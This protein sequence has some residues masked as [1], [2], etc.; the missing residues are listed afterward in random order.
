MKNRLLKNTVI[1]A[2]GNLG[3]KI[4]TFLLV[5]LY[6]YVLSTQE[7]GKV[8]LVTTSL[9]LL[10]PVVL[11]NIFDSSLR[12]TLD[13]KEKNE[14]VLSSSILVF[15]FTMILSLFIALVIVTKSDS[16]EYLYYYLILFSQGL[17]QI[18][19]QYARGIGK[20]KSFAFSGILYTFVLMAANIYLLVWKKVGINGY[21]LS[22][23]L[24]NIL[25]CIFLLIVIGKLR[26]S[27]NKKLLLSML[28]YSIPLIP[29]SIMWWIMNASDRYMISYFLGFEVNGLYAVA[30]KIPAILNTLYLIFNQAWQIEAVSNKNENSQTK[31]FNKVIILNLLVSSIMIVCSKFLVPI[32]GADYSDF[33][34][35]TP[36]L[37][38]AT[39]FSILSTFLG[40]NYLV[41]KDTKKIM[42]TTINGA[43]I[44]LVLNLLFIPSIGAN[45]AAL[46][47]FISFFY[48]FFVRFT[49]CKK[50]NFIKTNLKVYLPAFIVCVFLG[51]YQIV[52]DTSF[53]IELVLLILIIILI[54]KG[55]KKNENISNGC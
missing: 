46:A 34:K 22:M 18:L 23:I 17:S 30:N 49:D 38:V 52:I 50:S 43:I 31:L 10:V 28:R 1:F 12:F 42:K 53:V 7:Y 26:F 35:Y 47:T 16:K 5:P 15:I 51:F 4:I 27:F 2:V 11:L 29:N 55:G 21:F 54:I 40:V 14:D 44:N 25:T 36:F 32:F 19:S 3:S 8:D 6:T 9:N 37:I 33:Y 24:A 20:V 39:M 13:K 48:V 41:I 45:G